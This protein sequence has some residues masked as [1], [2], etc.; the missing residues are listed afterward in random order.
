MSLSLTK[1]LVFRKLGGNH[2][3]QG[4]SVSANNCVPRPSTTLILPPWL[5]PYWAKPPMTRVVSENLLTVCSCPRAHSY[6][7]ELPELKGHRLS[8]ESATYRA[9]A[10]LG[11]PSRTSRPNI[12]P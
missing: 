12:G 11:F 6:G 5:A 10:R 4:N 7:L 1:E 8:L 2:Y 9:D 3:I